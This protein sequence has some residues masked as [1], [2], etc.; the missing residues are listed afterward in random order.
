[1]GAAVGGGRCRAGL[2]PKKNMNG[3]PE[4]WKEGDIFNGDSWCPSLRSSCSGKAG[5]RVSSSRKRVPSLKD[6]LQPSL[7]RRHQP[8]P[9]LGQL[10]ALATCRPAPAGALGHKP[11]GTE[12]RGTC[13]SPLTPR[14]HSAQ[15]ANGHTGTRHPHIHPEPFPQGNG[16][17]QIH[18]PRRSGQGG[19]GLSLR[20]N[21]FGGGGNCVCVRETE[22]QTDREGN[23]I[24][25]NLGWCIFFNHICDSR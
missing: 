17:K 14:R 9:R 11:P 4:D 5:H 23:Y 21:I 10:Q 24:F 20:W 6:P 19:G 25:I 12:S 8:Q 15:T 18:P 16:E 22:T 13:M 7:A 1:M 3:K 2:N